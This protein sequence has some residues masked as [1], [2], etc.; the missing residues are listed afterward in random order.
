MIKIQGY[1][2]ISAKDLRDNM[3]GRI[4]PKLSRVAIAYQLKTSYQTID[5]VFTLNNNKIKAS[6]RVVCQVATLMGIKVIVVENGTKQYFI[7]Q[8]KK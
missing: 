5:N 7:N 2:E 6:D 1:K 4:N 3:K 8:S